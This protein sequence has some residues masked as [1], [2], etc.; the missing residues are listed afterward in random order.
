MSPYAP[1][2]FKEMWDKGPPPNSFFDDILLP[3][4][5]INLL[6]VLIIWAV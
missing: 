6:A 3:Y 4:F 1:L 2:W 5:S